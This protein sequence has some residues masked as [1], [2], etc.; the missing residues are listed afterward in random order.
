MIYQQ[1]VLVTDKANEISPFK[2]WSF[3]FK[4]AIYDRTP[5]R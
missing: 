3:S 4:N 1:S 5:V 2:W